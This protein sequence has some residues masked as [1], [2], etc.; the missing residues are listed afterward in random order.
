MVN[1]S[2][3]LSIVK[4]KSTSLNCNVG[5][6]WLPGFAALQCAVKGNQVHLKY[7]YIHFKL[8]FFLFIYQEKNASIFNKDPLLVVLIKKDHLNWAFAAILRLCNLKLPHFR[9]S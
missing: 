3:Q 5:Q 2:H 7:V 8:S 1:R 6:S 4:G 9:W